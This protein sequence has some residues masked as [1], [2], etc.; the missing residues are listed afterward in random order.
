MNIW[1]LALLFSLASAGV[2]TA[3]PD[4]DAGD[5]GDDFYVEFGATGST[6]VADTNL[7]AEVTI[8][9]P[10]P[11]VF[12]RS[13]FAVT[14]AGSA[15]NAYGLPFG[16]VTVT[17]HLQRDFTDFIGAEY[18]VNP[19][20]SAGLYAS[21]TATLTPA[22]FGPFFGTGIEGTL[23]GENLRMSGHLGLFFGPNIANPLANTT[24]GVVLDGQVSD[25]LTLFASYDYDRWGFWGL[26]VQSAKVGTV[27]DLGGF[28]GG[29]R[30]VDLELSVGQLNTN[31]LVFTQLH[32]GISF[33]TGA[34]SGRSDTKGIANTVYQTYLSRNG[35][36]EEYG[37]FTQPISLRSTF[38]F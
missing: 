32:A 27:I 36:R 5:P 13:N 7:G 20:L 6:S 11:S 35:E 26:N 23:A 14:V 17:G 24:A 30:P 3:E 37:Y 29:N 2:A 18:A 10:L 31:G 22:N 19:K 38:S 16:A 25:A 1:K 21:A 8:A 28:L 9:K 15:Q 12:P 33:T 4:E 34:P